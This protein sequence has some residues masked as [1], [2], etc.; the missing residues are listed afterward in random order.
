MYAAIYA[1]LFLAFVL[2]A[3]GSTFLYSDED[4]L[5]FMTC[6]QSEARL[7]VNRA[8]VC[9]VVYEFVDT[10]VPNTDQRDYIWAGCWPLDQVS[11]DVVWRREICMLLWPP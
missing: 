8:F 11:P 4:C 3:D 9:A 7:S 10:G 6:S 5:L 1:I 2:V